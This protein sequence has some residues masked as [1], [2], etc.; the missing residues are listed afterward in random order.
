MDRAF[1]LEYLQKNMDYHMD[2]D[3]VEALGQ[4]YK[5]AAR[6]GALKSVRGIEFL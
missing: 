2:S 1:L 6:A 4:F 3:G 5:M